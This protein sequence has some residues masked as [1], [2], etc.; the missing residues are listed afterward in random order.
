MIAPPAWLKR[1]TPAKWP[2]SRNLPMSN[3]EWKNRSRSSRNRVS[4][5]LGIFAQGH[6]SKVQEPADLE[7]VG[8]LGEVLGEVLD[9]QPGAR[10]VGV[11]GGRRDRQDAG[12]LAAAH[13]AVV[14]FAAAHRGRRPE[15]R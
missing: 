5:L 15:S 12:A 10:G 3:S 2:M 4:T 9:R 11:N 14:V 7:V 8:I 1:L 6:V 13:D